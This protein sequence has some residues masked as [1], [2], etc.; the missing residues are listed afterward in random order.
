MPAETSGARMDE[1]MRALAD[2]TRR[3]IVHPFRLLLFQPIP[4]FQPILPI[5]PIL[6]VLP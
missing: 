1:A 3:E 5:L 4:P 6:P 2:P